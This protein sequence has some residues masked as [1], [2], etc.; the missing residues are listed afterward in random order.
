MKVILM[1]R[2]THGHPL[3]LGRCTE[4][5]RLTLVFSAA[6]MVRP[7]LNDLRPVRFGRPEC[8]DPCQALECL[9]CDRLLRPAE[10]VHFLCRVLSPSPCAPT[11]FCFALRVSQRH[12]DVHD[13][14]ERRLWA[15]SEMAS[16]G[17]LTCSSQC[18]QRCWAPHACSVFF[19]FVL[20]VFVVNIHIM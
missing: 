6:G 17:Q 18:T 8:P 15:G 9:H 11:S 4:S 16:G 13:K 12:C 7:D 20:Q 5:L 14:L 10:C 1:A 3:L 2:G 19:Y